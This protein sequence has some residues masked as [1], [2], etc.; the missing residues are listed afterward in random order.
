MKCSSSS[1]WLGW[2]SSSRWKLLP[3][4]HFPCTIFKW[5]LM[6]RRFFW[7]IWFICIQHR[8]SFGLN[9]RNMVFFTGRHW[10]GCWRG[11]EIGILLNFYRPIETVEMNYYGMVLLLMD[12][13]IFFFSLWTTWCQNHQ[14]MRLLYTDEEKIQQNKLKLTVV[15]LRIKITN[16]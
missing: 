14:Q 10:H 2:I 11:K 13:N 3:N 9:R 6:C 8:K 16:L 15:Y 7:L 5:L 4:K 12:F 1:H